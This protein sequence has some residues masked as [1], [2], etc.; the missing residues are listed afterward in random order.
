MR[1][2]IH[3]YAASADD[4][5]AAMKDAGGV[6]FECFPFGGIVVGYIDVPG[7]TVRGILRKDSRVTLLPNRHSQGNDISKHAAALKIP[8]AKTARDIFSAVFSATNWDVYD[9]DF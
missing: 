5:E 7:H 9:P 4:M 2:R 8:N 1:H 3:V 6:A